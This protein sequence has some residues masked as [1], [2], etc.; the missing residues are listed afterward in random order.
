MLNDTQAAVSSYRLGYASFSSRLQVGSSRQI[1]GIKSIKDEKP[2]LAGRSL[3]SER[4]FDREAHQMLFFLVKSVLFVPA[5]L[6]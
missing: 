3:S 1:E 2:K 6:Q 5:Q 4:F